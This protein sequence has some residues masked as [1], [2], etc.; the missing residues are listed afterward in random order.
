MRTVCHLAA[1]L[2]FALAVLPAAAAAQKDRSDCE[3]MTNPGLKVGACTRLLQSGGMTVELKAS[4]H[5]HRGVGFLLQ[6][7]LD[8][9]IVEFNEAL[10]ADPAYKR[11][12]NSRGNAWKGRCRTISTF[13]T[14]KDQIDSLL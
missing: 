3:Q 9:A 10:R 6:S 14:T 11:S 13:A 12:Y 1:V 7:Q 5:H 8:R 2:T 4:A